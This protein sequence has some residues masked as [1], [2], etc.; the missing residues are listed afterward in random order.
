MINT[1][2]IHSNISRDCFHLQ[3][4]S[5]IELQNIL[6]SD[7]DNFFMLGYIHNAV[8]VSIKH[9]EINNNNFENNDYKISNFFY[10]QSESISLSNLK[11]QQ[12]TGNHGLN[13]HV[14]T[15]LF[16]FNCSSIKIQDIALNQI[17]YFTALFVLVSPSYFE[18]VNASFQSI[19]EVNRLIDFTALDERVGKLNRTLIFE[20]NTF[21]EVSVRYSMISIL[22]G[23]VSFSNVLFN[24]CY[25]MNYIDSSW[26]LESLQFVMEN[27]NFTNSYMDTCVELS[28]SNSSVV[29]NSTHIENTTFYYNRAYYGGG[30]QI[31]YSASLCPTIV[32][33]SFM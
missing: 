8:N 27:V 6:F 31:E 16:R 12:I 15:V 25:A 9:L 20:N 19:R 3:N 10:I 1:S 5:N 22:T 21:N 26:Q 13:D 17:S 18:M 2:I 30:V 7:A 28:A 11:A 23:S 4:V 24:Y 14:P 32:S 29:S 33:C